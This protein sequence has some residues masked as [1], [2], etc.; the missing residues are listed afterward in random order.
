MNL[1]TQQIIGKLPK[2][3]FV[4]QFSRYLSLLDYKK[5]IEGKKVLDIACGCGYGTYFIKKYLNAKSVVGVDS[6]VCAINYANEFFNNEDIN[7]I[8][9]NSYELSNDKKYFEFFDIII[10]FETIE[11]AYTPIAF[12]KELSIV[13]KNKCFL[14]LSTPNKKT[15]S[16]YVKFPIYK[17]HINEFTKDELVNLV[18]KSDF[19]ILE[20][21]SEMTKNTIM[22]NTR[23][24]ICY[25]LR[26]IKYK[27][28]SRFLE[29]TF[30]LLKNIINFSNEKVIINK[31]LVN[32]HLT[33]K[34]SS[35]NNEVIG[36][37]FVFLEK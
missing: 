13:S 32:S 7:Y 14:F 29:N 4:S 3:E 31:E 20:F 22:L 21:K 35:Q 6:D 17:Y 36:G 15:V 8:A 23:R 1:I 11:H 24:I 33:Y 19:K 37:F 25:L 27:F 16:P 30:Y 2:N 26:P 18:K 28:I 12:L 9:K 5:V 34:K 10:S